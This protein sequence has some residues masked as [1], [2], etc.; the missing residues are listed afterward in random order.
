ML[1]AILACLTL[2]LC[3]ASAL[4]DAEQDCKQGKD[5]DLRVRACTEIISRDGKAAWAYRM[6]GLAHKSKRDYDRAVVDYSKAIE[7]DPQDPFARLD[8]GTMYRLK[9]DHDRALADLTSAI[10][11]VQRK[12]PTDAKTGGKDS[13]AAKALADTI[14]AMEEYEGDLLFLNAYLERGYAFEALTRREEAIADF[15][16]ALAI[17][18]SIQES[19]DALKRLGAAP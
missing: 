2:V 4:A 5:L 17:D 18:P 15:R 7:I 12:T 14:A 9:G 3:A 10:E 8:R 16:R 19:R 1:K 13:P 6:R 11:T